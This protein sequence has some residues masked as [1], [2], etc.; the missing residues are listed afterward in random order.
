MIMR[1]RTITGAFIAATVYLVLYYS[2][3]SEVILMAPALLSA[4]AVYEIYHAAGVDGN[5]VLFTLSLVAAILVVFWDKPYYK[6]I[7]TVVFALSVGTFL[8]LMLLQKQAKL[9]SP[10]IAFYLVALMVFMICAINFCI[11]SNFLLFF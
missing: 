2:Y 8:L 6:E 11:F 1:K 3:I 9:N 4:F 7:I 5:E 10:I